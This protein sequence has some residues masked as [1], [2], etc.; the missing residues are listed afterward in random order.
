MMERFLPKHTGSEK[1]FTLVELLIVVAIIGIL[2]AVAIPQ[3]AQ[4][5][6]KSA[7]AAAEGGIAS[8]MSVLNAKYSDDSSVTNHSCQVGTTPCTL[9]LDT[10]TGAITGCG[11]VTIK[12]ISVTCSITNG[13]V[14]C[15]T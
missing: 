8:C 7:V 9:T 11:S 12:G 10:N 4:Y 5:K 15:H 13:Q 1:G 3:Y 2:A 14:S 6:K